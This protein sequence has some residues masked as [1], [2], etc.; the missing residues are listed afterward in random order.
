MTA[1][2]K[3]EE[4]A[5]KMCSSMDVFKPNPRSKRSAL[6]AVDEI[7]KVIEDNSLEYEDNYWVQVRLEIE[8]L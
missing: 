5:I 3:A 2:E 7:L 8:L 1:K 4:L 6:I